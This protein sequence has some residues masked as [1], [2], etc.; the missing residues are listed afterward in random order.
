MPIRINLLAEA[1]ALEDMRRR[2]PVKRAIWIASFLVVLVLLWSGSLQLKAIVA[3]S[4][5]AR[6][7]AQIA[8][9]GGAYEAVRAN[10]IKLAD[11]SQKLGALRQLA[12]NRFLKATLLNALQQATVD[13][14]QL[15]RLKAEE[16]YTFSEALKPKT[17]A[18]NRITPGRPATVTEAIVVTLDARDIGVNP[19]DQVNKFKMAVTDSPYFAATA[20]KTNQIRLTNLSPPQIGPDGKPYILFTLECRHPEVTR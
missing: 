4:D 3:K 8:S 2:D 19:G 11:M 10:Q 17:N 7:E 14:V 6:I 16:H 15:A 5:L 18:D 20:G 9:H 1:Q 13:D 12:T